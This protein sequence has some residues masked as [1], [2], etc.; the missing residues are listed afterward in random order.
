MIVQNLSNIFGQKVLEISFSFQ[1]VELRG[2][3]L[4]SAKRNAT[5]DGMT[6]STCDVTSSNDSVSEQDLQVETAVVTGKRGP[7]NG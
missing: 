7:G 2:E 1:F 3:V 6:S 4:D 5:I